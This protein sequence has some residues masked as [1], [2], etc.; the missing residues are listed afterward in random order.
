MKIFIVG[1]IS[2]FRGGISHSNQWLSEKLALNNDVTVISFKRLFPKILFPG[3]SQFEPLT[4]NLQE[5]FKKKFVLDSINPFNWLNV[6]FFFKKEKPD[7]IIFHW[8]HTFFAPMFALLSFLSKKSFKTKII[9]VMHNVLPHESQN[10]LHKFL[11]KT[12]FMNVDKFVFLSAAEEKFFKEIMP[13]AKTINF[14]IPTFEAVKKISGIKESKA[15]KL[16]GVDS[17]L[18]FFGFVRKYKGLDVLIEAMPE[19]LKS[20]KVK[21]F[22]VGEFWKDKEE[23]IKKINEL[24]IKDS[25]I[26]YDKYV[27]INEVEKY[28]KA[29]DA[30]VLPYI[31][32]THSGIIEMAFSFNTPIITTNVGGNTELIEDKINGLIVPPNNP[33]ALAK[34]IIFFYKNNL[35]KQFKEKMK[36]KKFEWNKEKEAL[37]LS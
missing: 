17:M 25:V 33:S 12:F 9:A 21:L 18:L 15:K 37:L 28:F 2:P 11:A 7:I 8:W 10:F 31:S 13:N 19:V 32:S 27:P 22:I 1:P 16:L 4:E 3:K 35:A 6:F 24:G 5:N 20:I 36:E 34:A 14:I 26:I 29:A 23:Y 30:I